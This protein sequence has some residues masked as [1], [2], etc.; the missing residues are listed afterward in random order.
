MKIEILLRNDVESLGECG[1]V[2]SVAPGYA[3][4]YL[5]PR[6]LAVEA[7]DDNKRQM[8]RRKVQLQAEAAVKTAEMEAWIGELAKVS[9]ATTERADAEGRLYG[10]VNAAAIVELLR[11]AGHT[12]EE[13]NVR[14]DAPIKNV[15]TH[16][17]KIHV[18]GERFAEIPLEVR[19]A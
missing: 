16:T 14:L 1:D 13:K 18:H 2:V 19:A 15:G 12:I 7:T 3:R 9:L 8:Q 11:A 17:V 10:S 6:R 4:N 5:F